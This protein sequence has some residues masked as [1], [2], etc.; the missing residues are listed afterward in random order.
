[1]DFFERLTRMGAMSEDTD[2]VWAAPKDAM[3][4]AEEIELLRDEHIDAMQP[5]PFK[6]GDIVTHIRTEIQEA[7]TKNGKTFPI[8]PIFEGVG[9]FLRPADFNL[10]SATQAA[11][12]NAVA[13]LLAFTETT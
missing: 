8:G 4:L 7:Q 2:D 13:K 1:M 5:N 9:G 11:R 10:E 6:V 3:R 12:E